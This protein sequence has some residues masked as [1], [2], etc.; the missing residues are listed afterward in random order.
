DANFDARFEDNFDGI[1]WAR[2]PDYMAPLR[3]QKHK[4][5][6]IYRHGYRVCLRRLPQRIFFVCAYC[7]RDKTIDRGGT[8]LYD[9]TA[10]TSSAAN[11]LQAQKRGHRL[12]PTGERIPLPGGQRTLQQ[13][14]QGGIIV[15]QAVGNALGNFDVQRFRIAAIEWLVANNHPLRE[16]ETPAFRNMLEM[17]NPEALGA[18]W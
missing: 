14:I 2:L 16:F 6:W 5:S 9:V 7:H 1:D 15:P 12:T 17:A 10:S 3:T 13:V 11:H 8:R 4:K 18:L